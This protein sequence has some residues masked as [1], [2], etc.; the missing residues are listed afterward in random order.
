M[1]NKTEGGLKMGHDEDGGVDSMDN[2]LDLSP[3]SL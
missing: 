1:Q 3:L 2:K